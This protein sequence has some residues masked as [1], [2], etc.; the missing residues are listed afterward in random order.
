MLIPSTSF[1][2]QTDR[3]YSLMK[4]GVNYLFGGKGQ[5]PLPTHNWTGFYA[6]LVGGSGVAQASATQ[7]GVAG[8]GVIGENAL[9]YTVGGLV[10]YNW[11]FT[12]QFVAGVE[13]DFSWLG[14]DRSQA[15]YNDFGGNRNAMLGMKTNWLATAR[16]RL[17]YSTGPALLY[18]TGGGAWVN[19]RDDWQGANGNVAGPPVS[20]TKTLSGFAAGGGIETLLFG[21]W[22]SRI[23]YLYVD[24]GSG[25]TL[26]STASMVVD[27]KFHL[28]R[29]AM[30]YRFG[31]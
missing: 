29:S 21:N 3:R 8:A 31:G 1:D 27:Q 25:D 18:V 2:V 28:F 13:G 5:P 9:G 6:G 30:T 20:S 16:G 22:T 4:F 17:G 10:G 7:P 26:A 14:I 15:Q 24:V 11:Q 19:V 23:E 12:P